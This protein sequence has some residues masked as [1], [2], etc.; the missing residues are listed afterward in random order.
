ML[1]NNFDVFSSDESIC[2]YRI[3]ICVFKIRVLFDWI[4]VYLL[5]VMYWGNLYFVR[6]YN[7]MGCI[8]FIF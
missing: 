7:E 2:K 3:E 5:I 6:L 8:K 1:V 4:L